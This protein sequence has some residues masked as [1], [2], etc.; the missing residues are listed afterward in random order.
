[1]CEQYILQKL[2]YMYANERGEGFLK[3]WWNSNQKF[4]VYSDL[5]IGGT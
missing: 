4:Y 5:K 3:V 2:Y 1:M